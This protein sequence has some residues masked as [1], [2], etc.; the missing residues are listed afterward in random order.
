M[1]LH[2]RLQRQTVKKADALGRLLNKHTFANML[3]NDTVGVKPTQ[4]VRGHLFYLGSH[5]R[6]V[7]AL[8]IR[9]MSTRFGSKPGGYVWAFVDPAAHILFLS[10]IFMAISHTPALGTSFLLFFA[11]GYIGFQF[12][13]AMA[14]YLNGALSANR[15]L[16]SYPN[17]APIDTI[18]SRYILQLGTTT[19]VAV[20]VFSAINLS[21]KTPLNIHWPFILEAALAASLLALGSALA[22]NVL[23]LKYPL[24]EKVF[25]IVTRPLFMVS[26]VFFLPDSLPHP[27]RDVILLNPLVHVVMLFRKGFYPEY[28][29][30]GFDA[31][32]LYSVA[33]P[34][35]L[36]GLLIFTGS[37]RSLRQ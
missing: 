28:R 31:G 35:L 13:Q 23:F 19:V 9:E 25:G 26:G 7:A 14:G 22:N 34:L 12:Y 32:F 20:F 10:V 8:L 3:A 33:L 4:P 2:S 16:L 11:T 5:V 36:A 1:T 30:A 37:R 15:A 21:L 17:V 6:V 27:A 18:F 24:Y 29:A